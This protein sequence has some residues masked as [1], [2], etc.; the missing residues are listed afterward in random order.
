MTATTTN[1]TDPAA[2]T[3]RAVLYLRVSTAKQAKTDL[4]PEGLSLPA[5][6]ESCL[7]KAEELGAEVVDEYVDRGE[8]AK[9]VDRPQFRKMVS[10]V[11]A[12]RDIDY[13]I[14]DKINRFARNRRDD[15]NMLFE[16]RAA[17]ATVISV[18]ENIDDTPAGMLMHGILATLAEY[19]SRNN[20]TE[21]LKGMT[22]KAQVGGTPGRA[23]IGY[24]NVRLPVPGQPRGMADV[25]VDPERAP[26]VRWAFEQYATGEWTTQSLADALDARGLR[27]VSVGK[28]PS[29]PLLKSR[30]AHMLGNRY[31][32]GTVTFRGVQYKGRHEPIVDKALFERV[33]T[34]LRVKATTGEKTSKHHHYLKGTVFCGECHSRLVFSRNRGNG[35]SYDYFKCMGRQNGVACTVGYV[36]ADWLESQV[37][38][39]WQQNVFPTELA[40]ELRG[41]VLARLQVMH[42]GA[43]EQLGVQTKRLQDLDGERS[44]LLKAHL[45]GAVPLDL[46]KSEQDRIAREMSQAQVEIAAASMESA[47]VE[48]TLN[49]AL[50]L[51]EDCQETYLDAKPVRRREL[52]QAFFER[53]EVVP[54]EGVELTLNSPFRE[55][56]ELRGLR[57]GDEE[58]T[59]RLDGVLGRQGSAGNE[60]APAEWAGA[61]DEVVG[62]EPT[63]GWG[64]NTQRGRRYCR[65]DGWNMRDLVPPAGLEPATVGLEVR[66]SIQLSYRGQHGLATG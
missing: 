60:E 12:D 53:I 40:A 24:L 47:E 16:L 32:V 27:S 62:W 19:E 28:R 39:E 58:A 65:T 57:D 49:A 3:T 41:A 30:V 23:P 46:L 61:E 29:K 14:L 50:K 22:R 45:A 11:Q 64:S 42:Q 17:G 51:A 18:K 6:R 52:N 36:R 59:G 55:L 26:H 13:V 1:Q 15:A 21:A 56:R 2:R 5:Q 43:S 34:V 31:Y 4:D 8:S 10:R 25:E 9:T 44:T 7:R 38:T 66:C 33:Q 63:D 35:G 54:D 37:D 48:R 20:G